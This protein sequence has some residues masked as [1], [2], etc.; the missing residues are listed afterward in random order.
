MT[1]NQLKKGFW[2]K[3]LAELGLESPGYHEAV[4]ATNEFT[5]YKKDHPEEVKAAKAKAKKKP[6]RKR[7]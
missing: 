3:L 5:Q 4:K 6:T 7:K 1:G 2:T